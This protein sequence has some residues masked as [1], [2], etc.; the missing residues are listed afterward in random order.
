M[1]VR[2]EVIPVETEGADPDLSGVIDDRKRVEDGSA[3]AATEGGVG[4]E[5]GGGG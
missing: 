4:E 5:R 1:I 3:I 2:G